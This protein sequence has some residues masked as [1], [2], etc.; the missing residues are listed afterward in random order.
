MA[1]GPFERITVDTIAMPSSIVIVRRNRLL[2][3]SEFISRFAALTFC[4][5]KHFDLAVKPQN[6]STDVEITIAEHFFRRSHP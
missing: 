3:A 2:S 1:A 4:P 6:F 5:L